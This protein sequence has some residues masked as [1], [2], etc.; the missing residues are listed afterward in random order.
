MICSLHGEALLDPHVSLRVPH[1]R[2]A[3]EGVGPI[4]KQWEGEV[5][6]RLNEIQWLQISQPAQPSPRK[7]GYPPSPP[8]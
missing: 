3:G 5:V 8:R 7:R 6:L 4:A 2:A 1:R